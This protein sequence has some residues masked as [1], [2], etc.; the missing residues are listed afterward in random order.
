MPV[1]IHDDF[2]RSA[3]GDR[4]EVEESTFKQIKGVRRPNCHL[5]EAIELIDR[6]VPLFLDIKPD[7][8]TQPILNVLTSFY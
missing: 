5:A 6:R 4:L 3:G 8:Y 2:L 7:V 1:L